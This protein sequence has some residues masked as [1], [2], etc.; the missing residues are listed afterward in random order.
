MKDAVVIGPVLI[1]GAFALNGVSEA[2]YHGGTSAFEYLLFLAFLG[3]V[4]LVWYRMKLRS[5]ERM[6]ALALGRERDRAPAPREALSAGAAAVASN[7]STAMVIAGPV[8]VS[9]FAWLT[10]LTTSSDPQ[11]VWSVAGLLGVTSMVCGT[12][13]LARK[14][15]DAH[16]REVGGWLTSRKPPVYDPD[17]IDLVG[18]R[19]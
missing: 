19:G 18:R 12:V 15:P 4:L 11:F 10:S 1:A 17:A 8:G 7:P 13:L 2:S 16:G 6:K 9:L 5:S 3:V 14:S